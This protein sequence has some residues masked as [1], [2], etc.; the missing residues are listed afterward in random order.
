MKLQTQHYHFDLSHAFD[1]SIGIEFGNGLR[2]FGVDWAQKSPMKQEGFVGSVD[3]GGSCNCDQITLVP[4]CQS[5]HTECVGHI[6]KDS[7]SINDIHSVLLKVAQVV[8]IDAQI[9]SLKDVERI[10]IEPDV[11]ALVI[12]TLPNDIEKKTKTYSDQACYILPEA[13]QWIN[14]QGIE[15]LLVDFPSIDPMQDGGKLLAHRAFWNV[16]E[17]QVEMDVKTQRHKTITELI[18]V[19]NTVKDDVYLLDLQVANIALDASLARPILYP[20]ET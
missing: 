12:R 20:K 2:A 19:P 13:I 5:T 18:Y 11:K 10:S 3:G 15:H 9:I 16:S 4:H 6:L 17:G 8:T 7:L 14:Q 1:L